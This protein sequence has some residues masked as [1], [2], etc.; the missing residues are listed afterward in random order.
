MTFI[1]RNALWRYYPSFILSGLSIVA[2]LVELKSEYFGKEACTTSLSDCR[3]SKVHCEIKSYGASFRS[4][5]ILHFIV[6]AQ[7]ILKP[8]AHSFSPIF[9][10]L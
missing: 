5:F 2:P 1:H 10:R 6:S 7:F 4:P 9:M 8:V 3:Y